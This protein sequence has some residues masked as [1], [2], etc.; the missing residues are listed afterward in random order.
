MLA[1]NRP[2]YRISRRTAASKEG[3]QIMKPL[4]TKLASAAAMF[5]LVGSASLALAQA[6]DPGVRQTDDALIAQVQDQPGTAPMPP[7]AQGMRRMTPETMQQM[8]DMMMGGQMM[9][10]QAVGWGPGMM[11]R[12]DM[13]GT[14]MMGMMGPH[15]M[16]G[17]QGTMGAMM[18]MMFA[19]M[20]ADGDG[21]LSR[22]EFAQA[23]D[24]IFN[25][26]DADGDRQLTLQEMQA[27]LIG[28]R[29]PMFPDEEP[30]V[31]LDGEE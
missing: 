20:D 25:H 16:M 27:F 29:R 28:P 8:R 26:M 24:R 13:M 7:R 2:S 19:L 17:H 15:M 30:A 23:H 12:G 6:E 10:G 21:S 5:M 22:E 11:P 18:R 31:D 9:G 1:G 14:G 3:D 4:S